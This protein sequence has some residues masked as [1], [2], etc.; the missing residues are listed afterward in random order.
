MRTLYEDDEK[1]GGI[2]DFG[3][4]SEGFCAKVITRGAGKIVWILCFEDN[5]K[6]INFINMLR[7]LKIDEQHEEGILAMKHNPATEKKDTIQD[8]LNPNKNTDRTKN[9]PKLSKDKNGNLVVGFNST[10]NQL[11]TDGYWII[12]QDWTQCSL[13]CGGGTSTLQRM[14]V[15]PKSGGK[16]CI[17]DR[18]TTKPCNMHPCPDVFK[19]DELKNNQT[20][21]NKAIIKSMPFSNKPQRYVKCK[22]KES[23]LMLF[24]N[25][26][27]PNFKKNPIV[28]NQNLN[29]ANSISI[30][31][32]AIMNNSTFTLF[33]GEETE[34]LFMSFNLVASRFIRSTQK[35]CFQIYESSKKY[36]T[37]C[38]FGCDNSDKALEEWDYDFNLFKYQCNYKRPVDDEIKRKLDDKIV[39]I[40]YYYIN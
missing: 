23:D 18:I 3:D 29:G 13:K 14:C 39:N 33:T 30:P 22:I 19:T 35:G 38:P 27:D 10:E 12:L 21:I 40:N 4:F 32:R 24:Q 28:G 2:T 11:L 34:S 8:L 26:T 36:A 31:M 20:T 17:G 25:V 16:E 1:I 15:P 5:P 7:S 6:K 37:L 9:H